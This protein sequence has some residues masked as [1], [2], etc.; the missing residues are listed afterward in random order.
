MHSS[1]FLFE[2]GNSSLA[3]FART[4][5]SQNFLHGVPVTANQDPSR[6]GMYEQ[7]EILDEPVLQFLSFPQVRF[8]L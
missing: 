2:A 7:L 6:Y 3:P 1:S 4:S 8:F 5:S